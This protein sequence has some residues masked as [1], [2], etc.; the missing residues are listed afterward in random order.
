MKSLVSPKPYQL[1]ATIF[2]A[3]QS[4]LFSVQGS[5]LGVYARYSTTSG[6]EN[7]GIVDSIYRISWANFWLIAVLAIGA[8]IC[9]TYLA[10]NEASFVLQLLFFCTIIVPICFVI[11]VYV[12]VD[13]L[14]KPVRY[15]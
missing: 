7:A 3:L 13:S 12:L 14:R 2:I 10:I 15:G 6:F 8:S 1:G 11:F 9:L 5:L 4:I